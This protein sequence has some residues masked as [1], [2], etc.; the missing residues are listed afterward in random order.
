MKWYRSCNKPFAFSPRDP[1][2]GG[3]YVLIGTVHLLE[4]RTDEAIAWLQKARA[5]IPAAPVVHSRLAAAYALRGE[6]ERADAEL[7]EARKLNGGDVFSSIARLPTTAAVISRPVSRALE[8]VTSQ[9]W[10]A[11]CGPP[12]PRMHPRLRP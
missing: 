8:G 10:L 9:G 7:T 11:I 3:C 2:I 4:S 5:A 1:L 6:I 12:R